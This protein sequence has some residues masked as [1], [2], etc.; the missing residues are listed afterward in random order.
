[1]KDDYTTHSHYLTYTFLFKRLGEY[2]LWAW[3]RKGCSKRE[4]PVSSLVYSVRLFPFTCGMFIELRPFQERAVKFLVVRGRDLFSRRTAE[5][6]ERQLCW[7][8]V[9]NVSH[10]CAFVGNCPERSW[11]V[12][13][14]WEIAS[15]WEAWPP[16]RG[17]A[18]GRWI[19]RSKSVCTPAVLFWLC[20]Q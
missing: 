11:H 19:W 9:P 6:R 13:E 4:R 2:A 8:S 14:N 12:P 3:E 1:M 17:L 20:L 10:A 15:G 5:W 18:E 7:Q 16:N